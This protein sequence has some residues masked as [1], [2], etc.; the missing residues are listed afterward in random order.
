[1]PLPRLGHKGYKAIEPSNM[2]LEDQIQLFRGAKYV[3]GSMGAAMTNV[4]FCDPCTKVTL[5]VPGTFPDTFFWFIAQHKNLNYLEIRGDQVTYE[6]PNSWMAGYTI[7]EK[8]IEYLE[9]NS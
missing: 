7:R 1:M 6:G 5:L 9:A 8:D 2:A 4:V 3:V